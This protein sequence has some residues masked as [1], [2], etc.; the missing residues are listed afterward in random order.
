LTVDL[1][2][3][4][5]VVGNRIVIV[6]A[7][8]DRQRQAELR[9]APLYEEK[10]EGFAK[11]RF[12]FAREGAQVVGNPKVNKVGV[13]VVMDVTRIVAVEVDVVVVRTVVVKV[14]EGVV[15]V[16]EENTKGAAFTVFVPVANER[17]C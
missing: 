14:V 9:S 1:A 7:G 8:V 2:A 3:A 6:G 15:V 5:E 12:L 13:A 4:V 10:H 17:S 11:S 16:W